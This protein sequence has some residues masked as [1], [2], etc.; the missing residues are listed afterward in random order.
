MKSR[1]SSG[2][3]IIGG[4][5]RMNFLLLERTRGRTLWN[6]SDSRAWWLFNWRRRRTNIEGFLWPTERDSRICASGYGKC[7][8]ISIA[9]TKG[10]PATLISK[11]ISRHMRKRREMGADRPHRYGTKAN[12]GLRTGR[13]KDNT[14]WRNIRNSQITKM[15]SIKCHTF[16]RL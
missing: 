11:L 7:P 12:S 5:A 3:R 10:N 15:P 8:I 1:W 16:S 4:H 6:W 14:W 2:M 9:E 13:A